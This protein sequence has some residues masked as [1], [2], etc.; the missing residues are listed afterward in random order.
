MPWKTLKN[1]TQILVRPNKYEY[2]ETLI[3][4]AGMVPAISGRAMDALSRGGSV[5]I[6]VVEES[7]ASTVATS[8]K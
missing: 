6:K 4:M 7:P 8:S 1:G 3:A 2:N 5:K